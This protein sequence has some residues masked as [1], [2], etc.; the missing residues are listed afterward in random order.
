MHWD[1]HRPCPQQQRVTVGQGH[2]CHQ[3]QAGSGVAHRH[4]AGSG[5]SAGLTVS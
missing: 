1:T 2:L 4:P 5:G 3:H